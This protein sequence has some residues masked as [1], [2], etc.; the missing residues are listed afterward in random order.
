MRRRPA[1]SRLAPDPAGRGRGRQPRRRNGWQTAPHPSMSA[2][3]VESGVELAQ[4]V[5]P[6]RTHAVSVAL[7]ADTGQAVAAVQ[8]RDR[9]DG[10]R[11]AGRRGR[12][13]RRRAR[14]G[15][16]SPTPPL[17]AAGGG[18]FEQ[19]RTRITV[20]DTHAARP[21][22]LGGRCG[23]PSSRLPRSRRRSCPGSLLHRRTR[24]R[25]TRSSSCSPTSK[26]SCS[27]TRCTHDA[28][29]DR[30]PGAT[31]RRRARRRP[32]PGQLLTIPNVE[33]LT[34]G[35]NWSAATGDVT[36]TLE[37]LADAVLAANDDPHI[38]APRLKDRPLRPALQ[39]GAAHLGPVRL[40]RRA[41]ARTATPSS[42]RSRTSGSSTTAPC[43][44]GDYV[45]MP[46]WLANAAPSAY[47]SR[48]QENRLRRGERREDAA[49]SGT[50]GDHVGRAAR[51]GAAR[52]HRPRRPRASSH[53]RPGRRHRARPTGRPSTEGDRHART[54]RGDGV[55]RRRR[56]ELLERLRTRRHDWWWWPRA[57]GRRR[58]GHRRRRRR[59]PLPRPVHHRRRRQ[60]HWAEPVRGVLDFR[61]LPAAA[62][63]CP[64]A[65]SPTAST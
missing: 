55:R 48:S 45:E 24:R 59:P 35:M 42:A 25:L 50:R 56:R 65:P 63:T 37:H 11:R 30:P 9:G 40:P 54:R 27:P 28:D 17:L 57:L 23:H 1:R 16:D 36:Y 52:D 62:S 51:R 64:P 34:V 5:T 15:A 3:R 33:I 22:R 31:R 47:P 60:R 43:I 39:R 19:R 21:D 32:R 58:P 61:D 13:G 49:A 2:R 44:V 38:L 4:A 20:R 7:E 8:A 26:R 18:G 14:D 6:L 12:H 10:Q 29:A 41:A 53:R 46:D